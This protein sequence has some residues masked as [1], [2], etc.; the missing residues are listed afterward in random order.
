MG[1][2]TAARARV[3]VGG[4]VVVT[5]PGR[6]A[7]YTVV[8]RAVFAASRSDGAGFTPAGLHRVAPAA[9]PSSVGVDLAPGVTAAAADR[10]ARR[11][12][13]AA[14]QRVPDPEVDPPEPPAEA[15][16]LK[17]VDGLPLALA[18]ALGLAAVVTLAQALM[19]YFRA[20]RHDAAV[21]RVIGF[22]RT[23]ARRVLVGQ[24]LLLALAGVAAGTVLG[25]AAGRFLWWRWAADLGVV[26]EAVSPVGLLVLSVLVAAVAA[27]AVAVPLAARATGGPVAAVLRTE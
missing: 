25:V 10:V 15:M 7:R 9:G 27:F 5:A 6:R 16:H 1:S 26:P 11:A 24:G 2:R 22:R 19:L 8:G 13:D 3:P 17:A 4:S 14:Q 12:Q 20:R 21:M 18:V 23:E